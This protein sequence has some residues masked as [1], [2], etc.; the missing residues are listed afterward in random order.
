M[1][2]TSAPA[3]TSASLSCG[4]TRGLLR[5]T[6]SSLPRR[7]CLG[8]LHVR[9]LIC[10]AVRL[11][12]YSAVHH[13]A[14]SV[15]RPQPTVRGP[16]LTHTPSSRPSLRAPC[17]QAARHTPS[18]PL[19]HPPPSR[20][21]LPWRHAPPAVAVTLA[22]GVSRT[23]RATL[24]SHSDDAP[25]TSSSTRH[26]TRVTRH[27][28]ASCTTRRTPLT[29]PTPLPTPPSSPL[30][31]SHFHTPPP[32]ITRKETTERRRRSG[33]R[34]V[35][36]RAKDGGR[37]AESEGNAGVAGGRRG[38]GGREGV[39]RRVKAGGRRILEGG[40]GESRPLEG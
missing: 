38:G 17:A 32:V 36:R 11:E 22:S 39:P 2:R 23:R 1:A 13:L 33:G 26:H 16:S 21:P 35:K 34:R 8:L 24:E 4:K 18:V 9:L 10:R 19:D 31:T 30:L 27:T 14:Y 7:T 3:R 20:R 28:R 6:L 25:H 12:A 5:G 40:G 29:S 37:R 15:V